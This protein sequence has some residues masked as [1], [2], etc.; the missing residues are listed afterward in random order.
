[1]NA[2][3]LGERRAHAILIVAIGANPKRLLFVEKVNI[4]SAFFQR[5]FYI[6][7]VRNGNLKQAV[8]ELYFAKKSMNV[9]NAVGSFYSNGRVRPL[10]ANS[11]TYYLCDPPH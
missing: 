7:N 5:V 1:M 3:D 2:T 6:L 11:C 9:F 4:P 10:Q 8:Q